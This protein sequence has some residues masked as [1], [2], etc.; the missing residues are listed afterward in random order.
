M[1]SV[2]VSG[3]ILKGFSV[4]LEVADVAAFHALPDSEQQATIAEALGLRRF[5]REE[6]IRIDNIEPPESSL[7]IPVREQRMASQSA[8]VP[9]NELVAA[10]EWAREDETVAA[11]LV[12]AYRGRQAACGVAWTGEQSGLPGS[13]DELS[14]A[15]ADYCEAVTHDDDTMRRNAV[16]MVRRAVLAQSAYRVGSGND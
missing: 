8:H 4:E 12:R 11:F 6:G 2:R 13:I 14:V 16:A 10:L 15:L 3:D 9:A 5:G 1:P 7:F